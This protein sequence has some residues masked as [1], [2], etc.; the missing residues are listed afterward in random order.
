MAIAIGV[1]LSFLL[2]KSLTD[3]NYKPVPKNAILYEMR[4]ND[5]SLGEVYKFDAGME[6]ES[7]S[8]LI[9]GSEEELDSLDWHYN[10][11]D[12]VDVTGT[13]NY[14]AGMMVLRPDDI[15]KCQ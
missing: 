14:H 2:T 4:W 12:C 6:G 13:G 5:P 7:D 3:E 10:I 9:L 15:R 8:Y 1:V 11:G